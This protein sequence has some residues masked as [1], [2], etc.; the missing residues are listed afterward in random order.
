[1]RLKQQFILYGL[2][3]INVLIFLAQEMGL[4]WRNVGALWLPVSPFY[5]HWQWLSYAFLHE[6]LLHIGLNMYALGMF[7]A[8]L[9]RIW[10]AK[11][12]LLLYLISALV[13]A[14]LYCGWQMVS[15]MQ[16]VPQL[17]SSASVQQSVFALLS[18]PMLGA[19]GA[20]FGL[21]AA[22]AIRL[23]HVQLGLMFLPVHLPACYFVG[24]IVAYEVF[25]QVSGYS[26]FGDNIAHMA[27][28][29]G[30]IAG[31]VFGWWFL[32][33]ERR[34]MAMMLPENMPSCDQ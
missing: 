22:F 5:H 11:R 25:A 26:L 12:F 33:Q 17:A 24:V 32:R 19:S 31:A 16:V 9:L 8:P 27:H 4:D 2:I 15:L 20:V 18:S 6:D 21:L 10:G 29:G 34:E 3:G 14:T 7:G 23:P 13:A 30:A 28:V 1:M